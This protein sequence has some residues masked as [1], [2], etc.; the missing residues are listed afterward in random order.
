MESEHCYYMK[1]VKIICPTCG[2]DEIHEFENGTWLLEN[3]PLP[4]FSCINRHLFSI[5]AL[6][7]M[8]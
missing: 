5:G 6:E 4:H 2:S 7:W 1:K 3:A 8:L